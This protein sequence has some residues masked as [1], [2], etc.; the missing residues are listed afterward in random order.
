MINTAEKNGS[1][2]LQR[3]KQCGGSYKQDFMGELIANFN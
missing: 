3:E 1:N 2:I